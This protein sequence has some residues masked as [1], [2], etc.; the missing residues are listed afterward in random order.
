MQQPDRSE[1][2]AKPVGQEGDIAGQR[3]HPQGNEVLHAERCDD[4][5]GGQES[6]GFQKAHDVAPRPRPESREKSD[7]IIERTYW[8]RAC[9]ART[10]WNAMPAEL[11]LLRRASVFMVL[12]VCRSNPPG[13]I[14]GRRCVEAFV[15]AVTAV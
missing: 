13:A 8:A 7:E 11:S 5:T 10:L 2:E 9:C 4:E 12:P 14:V 1:A 6:H 3:R 15:A